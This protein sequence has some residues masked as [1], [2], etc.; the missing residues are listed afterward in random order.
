MALTSKQDVANTPKMRPNRV[1][2]KLSDA[3]HKV[4]ISNGTR[5]RIQASGDFAHGVG[6]VVAELNRRGIRTMRGGM[7]GGDWIDEPRPEAAQRGSWPPSGE[8]DDPAEIVCRRECY[9]AVVRQTQPKRGQRQR[10][11]V[12]STMR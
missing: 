1:V 3:S 6:P 2:S 11:T 10:S 5:W 7:R 9:L 8:P 12:W 4:Q